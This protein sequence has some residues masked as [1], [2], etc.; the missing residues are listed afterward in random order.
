MA[1]KLAVMA[2]NALRNY[3]VDRALELLEEIRLTCDPDA[4]WE[5]APTLNVVK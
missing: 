3:D 2:A 4:R 5:T 1:A